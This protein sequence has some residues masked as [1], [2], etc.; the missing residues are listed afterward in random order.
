MQPNTIAYT[1]DHDN[2]GGSTAAVAVTLTRHAEEL[3]KSTYRT[4]DHSPTNPDTMSFFRTL[5]K[6]SGDFLGVERVAVKRTRTETVESAAGLE[7]KAASNIEVAINLP[8][9]LTVAEKTARLME[10]LGFL[11]STEGKTAMLL[12]INVQSI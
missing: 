10:L 11:S 6:R 2:D 9:G 7:T 1:Y 4:A 12:L 8:V 5:P 3:H